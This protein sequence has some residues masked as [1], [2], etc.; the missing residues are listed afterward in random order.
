[1][2]VVAIAFHAEKLHDD[3]IWRLVERFARCMELN[4]IRA[5]FFVYPFRSQIAGADITHRVRAVAAL[6]HE[7]GQHT[8]FYAGENV[9]KGNKVDDLS[10]GN[11][12]RCLSRDFETLRQ[13]GFAPKM[14]TAGAWFVNPILYETLVG[15]GFR[16][17]WS[18]QFPKPQTSFSS[19]YNSWLRSPCFSSNSRGRILCLPTTCSLGEWFK[20][21]RTVM[22]EGTLPYQLIYLHDYD[23]LTLRNRVLSSIFRYISRR[24]T[25]MSLSAIAQQYETV[26][27]E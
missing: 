9:E 25:F 5:T 21:G 15:L 6:G 27:T 23:L 8:H 18:A 3:Q 26:G 11:I 2:S 14:F 24:R 22:T 19:P 13:M 7:I 12:V 1:M 10:Q 20:W 16:Y 17:D 4:N